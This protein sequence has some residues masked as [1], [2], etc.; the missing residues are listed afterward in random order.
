MYFQ[1]IMYS[2]FRLYV[3]K[4]LTELTVWHNV[5]LPAEVCDGPGEVVV[6]VILLVPVAPARCLNGGLLG[7]IFPLTVLSSCSCRR[8]HA[9]YY[10]SA[11]HNT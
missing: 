1:W 4:V 6:D 8:C 5:D 10:L 7:R 11:T 3:F 9:I 2:V